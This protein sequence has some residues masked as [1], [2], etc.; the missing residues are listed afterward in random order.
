MTVGE[1]INILARIS[2]DKPVV[3]GG[4]SKLDY[5]GEGISYG[6]TYGPF[7]VREKE[8]RVEIYR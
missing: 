3:S 6:Y 2:P 5:G 4:I 7:A 8:D 1:L